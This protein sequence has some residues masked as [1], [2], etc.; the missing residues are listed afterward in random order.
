MSRRLRRPKF[1]RDLPPRPIPA[2]LAVLHV[3]GDRHDE[4]EQFIGG[5]VIVALRLARVAGADEEALHVR[6]LRRHLEGG[7]LHRLDRS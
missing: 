3:G 4:D 7:E 5:L 2:D 1:L 6:G